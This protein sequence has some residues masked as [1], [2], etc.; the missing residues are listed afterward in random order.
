MPVMPGAMLGVLG[1]GQLGRMF[2]QAA[3]QMGYQVTVLDPDR[4]SP[5]GRVADVFICAGYDDQAALEKIGQQCAAVTTEFENIPAESLRMLTKSCVVSPDA[6]SVS[7]A[8][9]RV[10]E[11][12]FLVDS[13]FS[14]AS[15]AVISQP[16]D[17]VTQD[18]AQF[19]P[20]ILKVSQFGYD[21]KGQ[22]KVA[23]V[24]ELQA[25]YEQLDHAVC[26]L[27]KFMPLKCEISVVVARGGNGEIATFP[28]SE[29]QHVNG[30]LDVSIVP[31]RISPLLADKAQAIACQAAEKLNYQ[32][33]LC[34]EFFVLQ[35]DALLINEIA[36]RPH[37]SGHY[38]IDACVTSQF[39]Q[40]VR[41]LCGLPLGSTTQLNP[42]VMINLLG[43]VWQNGDPDW[44]QVLRY[45]SA[46]LHLYGKTEA[47][48]GRKM[49]HFTVLGSDIATV[50]NDALHI[51]ERLNS[52]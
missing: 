33:V 5:A 35:D 31:A 7:I 17:I 26:V 22:V 44:N 23:T 14:V 46:K 50:L 15:F 38:S 48:P 11:K 10:R 41:T 13:G 42:A 40:Q 47:R 30:I 28:V 36:P 27:E 49:G 12:Q 34:V 25:A 32:G 20:G 45:P 6:N 37:N 52:N 8:Q 4:G 19:L 9:N 16:Q 43:D 18:V 51:K 39:E 3:Q 24:T 21:G 2:V 29:N 1:G